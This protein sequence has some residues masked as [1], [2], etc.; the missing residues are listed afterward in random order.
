MEYE[1]L[2]RCYNTVLKQRNAAEGEVIEL[3]NQL[4][5][6][7]DSLAIEEQR[8]LNAFQLIKNG[9][10]RSSLNFDDF[11]ILMD[12]NHDHNGNMKT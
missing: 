6:T 11:K 2:K 5:D 10:I 4:N 1:Q 3:T 8:L 7:L 12:K 9:V